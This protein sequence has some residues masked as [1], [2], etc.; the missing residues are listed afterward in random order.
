MTHLYGLLQ[1]ASRGDPAFLVEIGFV[2]QCHSFFLRSAHHIIILCLQLL[3]KLFF[4]LSN[5]F[6]EVLFL[7]ESLAQVFLG[8]FELID[9]VLQIKLHVLL[10]GHLRLV[11]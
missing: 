9:F 6:E 1:A 11:A 10:R 7:F 4:L 5:C 3:L 2:G 8:G